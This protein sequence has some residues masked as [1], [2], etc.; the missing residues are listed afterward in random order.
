MCGGKVETEGV[1][2]PFLV[3][4][5]E[6]AESHRPPASMREQRDKG[7]TDLIAKKKTAAFVVKISNTNHFSFSDVPF[8]VPETLMKKNG[9]FIK[10]Q[11]GFE[12][13]TRVLRAFFSWY[14][15]DREGEALEAVVKDYPEVS[16]SVFNQ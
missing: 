15:R 14:V 5:N 12:I 6:P 11:R 10:P 13:I 4:L 16:L 8:I 9:A 7:W 3:L 1:G 2:R